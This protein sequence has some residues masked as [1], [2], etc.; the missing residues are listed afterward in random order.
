MCLCGCIHVE[1]KAVV[2][3]FL[4]TSEV[5]ECESSNSLFFYVFFQD[6]YVTIRCENL[7][8]RA[9]F[10]VIHMMLSQTMF[11]R[12][13]DFLETRFRG[14]DLTDVAFLCSYSLRFEI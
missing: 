8:V 11:K 5:V 10:L 3:D 14:Y 4:T 7:F 12:R 6:Y 1:R 2:L 9:Q 13:Q